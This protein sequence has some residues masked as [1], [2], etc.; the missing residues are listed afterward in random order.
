MPSPSVTD[1]LPADPFVL[2][3]PVSREQG[4]L[5]GK[6]GRHVDQ[7]GPVVGADV[8]AGFDLEDAKVAADEGV[9]DRDAGETEPDGPGGPGVFPL[10]GQGTHQVRVE[11]GEIGRSDWRS[12]IRHH[13]RGVF[14]GPQ[15]SD[16]A[17]LIGLPAFELVVNMVR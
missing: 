3:G 13:V 16:C 5:V 14:A 12:V 2:D 10:L 9:V 15:V 8:G 4:T 7:D 17:S 6:A 11:S 1:G